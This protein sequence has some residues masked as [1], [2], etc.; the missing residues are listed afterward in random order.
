MPVAADLAEIQS[1]RT[2]FDGQN[3]HSHERHHSSPTSRHSQDRARAAASAGQRAHSPMPSSA[4]PTGRSSEHPS[5]HR[6]RRSP[7][8]P[9]S[10]DRAQP[11]SNSP[12]DPYRGTTQPDNS[13]SRRDAVFRYGS[14]SREQRPAQDDPVNA[15]AETFTSKLVLQPTFSPSIV[16]TPNH[17]QSPSRPDSRTEMHTRDSHSRAESR[18]GHSPPSFDGRIPGLGRPKTAAGPVRHS[19]LPSINSS[20][21]S[22][23]LVALSNFV[24]EPSNMLSALSPLVSSQTARRSQSDPSNNGRPMVRSQ[25]DSLVSSGQLLGTITETSGEPRSS[26]NLPQ[27]TP[28]SSRSTSGRP[29]PS[30][31]SSWRPMPTNDS[32]P[33]HSPLYH[34]PLPRPPLET[35]NP[36]TSAPFPAPPPPPPG[37]WKLRLR[38]GFWNRRGDC[39]TRDGYIV[40][41][42][43]NRAFPSELASYP[44]DAYVNEL[45]D[46]IEYVASRPELPE[47]L[48][49]HGRPPVQPYDMVR[50]TNS[51]AIS[52]LLC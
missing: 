15:L 41:A 51:Y 6:K 33:A 37:T 28:P 21:S 10:P 23:T 11:H 36:A 2:S 31:T 29:S 46:R 32:S 12:V 25:T 1:R 42:P 49:R 48:P 26:R 16:R 17:Y 35:H 38:K 44:D 22:D 34:N 52:K 50:S 43:E 13:Y 40:Y 5:S 27:L 19:S 8:S 20:S 9:H 4:S 24:D 3:K 7:R 30:P 39:L 45:G 14:P 18:N 47:S